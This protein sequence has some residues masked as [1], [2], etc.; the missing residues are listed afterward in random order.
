MQVVGK[1]HGE[2]IPRQPKG[3]QQDFYGTHNLSQ[4]FE[5]V[6]DKGKVTSRVLDMGYIGLMFGLV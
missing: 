4:S 5:I 3:Y 2:R 1:G 6:L